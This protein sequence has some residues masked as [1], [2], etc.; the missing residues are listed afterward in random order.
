LDTSLLPDG[1]YVV[2]VTAI[3]V[4]GNV[5]ADSM[6][7]TTDNGNPTSV[8][9]GG[10]GPSMAL[11]SYPNPAPGTSE[12]AFSLPDAGHAALSVHDLSGRLVRRLLATELPR[13]SHRVRWDGRDAR[14]SHV[15]SGVFFTTLTTPLGTRT[16]RLILLR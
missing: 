12:I 1:D 8:D 2:R 14:G 3:D 11:W 7:V 9:P 15:P 5:T 6:T 16:E 10:P 13:G 4:A